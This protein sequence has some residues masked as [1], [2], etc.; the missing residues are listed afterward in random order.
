MQLCPLQTQAYTPIQRSLYSLLKDFLH[1]L[2]NQ[3]QSPDED[4]GLTSA[5]SL[6]SF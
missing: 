3:G 6:Y 2:F 5:P 4:R 1:L